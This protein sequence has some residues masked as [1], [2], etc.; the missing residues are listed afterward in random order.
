MDLEDFR[1]SS[2]E[3]WG[4]MAPGWERWRAHIDE[5][6]APVRRWLI[7]TLAPRSGDTILELSAGVGDTGFEAAKLVGGAGG[8]LISSDFSPAMLEVARR[9][10]DEL[11]LTNVEYRVI[12]AE[13][14][15]LADDSVDGVLCRFGYM[16]MADPRRALTETR[17]VLRSG[18]RLVLAVWGPPERN[19]WGGVAAGI[20]MEQGHL[21]PPDPDAPSPF[22]MAS[23]ERTREMLTSAGFSEIDIEEVPVRFI[24]GDIAE[25]ESFATDTAGPFAMAI[26]ALDDDQRAAL[27]LRLDE[28]LAGF[29]A[30]GR[31][32]IPGVAL[33][34]VAN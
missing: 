2:F 24:V 26:R 19:P 12:D 31:Y 28:G 16:L 27:R 8:R 7:G 5:S 9:R 25:Y 32:E 18:G 33:G 1:R 22:S 30:G 17:R 23:E 13:Q 29:Q 20:L 4:A 3:T 21:P 14:I 6:T 11:G 34:A 10:G 15:E